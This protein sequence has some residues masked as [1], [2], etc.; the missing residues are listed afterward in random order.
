M[1]PPSFPSAICIT[2]RF[3]NQ[4]R[5][6]AHCLY[7][8]KPCLGF[9]V[10]DCVIVLESA[11]F[12]AWLCVCESVGRFVD[13]VI[14]LESVELDSDFAY[15]LESMIVCESK[16]LTQSHTS[17]TLCEALPD[18]K[19]NERDSARPKQNLWE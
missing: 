13:S 7:R 2:S 9:G 3:V 10:V 14:A 4:P 1:P 16:Q 18:I 17:K 15:F 12:G 11:L 19:N 8:A 6:R 5:H